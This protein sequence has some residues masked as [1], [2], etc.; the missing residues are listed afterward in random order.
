[1]ACT[2][3]V[4]SRNTR[5]HIGIDL[6]MY[7]MAGIGRYLQNLLPDLIPLLDVSAISILGRSA[8]LAEE[9]WLRDPRIRFT[10]FRS[11]I[12][13]VGEQLSSR[14]RQYRGLDLLW[15]PQYN[16]PLLY[17]GKLLVTIHDLCQLAHPETLGSTLQRHYAKYLLSAVAKRAS[18]I[19]C[20]SEFTASEIQK[21]LRVDQKRLVVTYPEAG[22]FGG[23]GIS[24]PSERTGNP[25]LLAVG[26]LKKHKNLPRL[27]S[28]FCG[29]QD[30]IP[31]DLVLVG[32]REGFLNSETQ[33]QGSD[34]PEGRVRFTGHV[35]D[36]ELRL[37]YRNATALIFPS[38]Y[39]G[40]G[41]PLVE[42]MAEGCPIACSNVASLP[43]VAG[44]AAL[45]FDPFSIESIAEAVLR[46]ATDGAI[47][48][49]LVVRGR[50]R[51]Q[52]FVG[53]RYATLTAAT[54][55][56]CLRE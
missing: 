43:E 25:Y 8:D 23:S 52:R 22:P 4:S 46:I 14:S 21:Y 13:S 5:L 44:D 50:E 18:A 51:V 47:R 1:M 10:E 40:F 36:D 56:A 54:I 33:F 34:F 27:I 49:S 31:H 30:R 20:V 7:R 39:E 45:L 15:V 42:A 35:S 3:F 48:D 2:N 26:N 19:L 12:F 9:T 32:R 11:R 16:I 55:T 37:Y 29:I 53:N 6:R 28:A 41:F 38:F 24:F 17:K